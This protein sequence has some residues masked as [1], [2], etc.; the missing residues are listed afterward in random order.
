MSSNEKTIQENIAEKYKEIMNM[1]CIL[2]DENNEKTPMRVAKML[3]ELFKNVNEPIDTL[4][5]Q[6]SLFPA[7]KH[8]TPIVIR[9]IPFTSMCSHHHM[10]FFGKVAVEYVPEE[11]IIGLSKVPRVVK[12]FSKKP[13]LQENLTNEIGEFLVEI[14]KPQFLTVHLYDCL[15]TCMLC[16]GVESQG[17]TDSTFAYQ[18]AYELISREEYD[19]VARKLLS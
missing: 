8:I 5:A 1:L 13:Q 2:P 16:R 11:T 3:L 17:L 19:N 7:P 9:D 12:F 4:L 18:K 14:I 15:H 10:P 6:M